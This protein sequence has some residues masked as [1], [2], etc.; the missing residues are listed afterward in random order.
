VNVLGFHSGGAQTRPHTRGAVP[1]KCLLTRLDHADRESRLNESTGA[2]LSSFVRFATIAKFG[3]GTPSETVGRL[4]M[5]SFP[6]VA[7]VCGTQGA[8]GPR[9]NALPG[10]ARPF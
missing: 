8:E 2:H 3:G 4:H 7:R 9:N 6:E 10:R 5:H 1:A